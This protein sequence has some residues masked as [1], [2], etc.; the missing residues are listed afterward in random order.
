[1]SSS[2]AL[3][4]QS[5]HVRQQSRK[6]PAEG[7]WSPTPPRSVSFAAER[8][9]SAWST[10]GEPDGPRLR[11]TAYPS[12]LRFER[13]RCAQRRPPRPSP[14]EWYGLVD[15]SRAIRSGRDRCVY[16]GRTH[17]WRQQRGIGQTPTT[18]AHMSRGRY[19]ARYT[20]IR[21]TR[22]N[23]LISDRPL[24]TAGGRPEHPRGRAEAHRRG[25]SQ[26]FED[27]HSP[28][29]SGDRARLS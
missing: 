27:V 22:T 4:L 8:D 21:R 19:C 15:A 29:S 6:P 16:Q 17:R 7:I 25:F 10:K 26:V 18:H 28:R 23:G 5:A 9:Q 20:H 12:R 1:M 13:P 2:A 14:N 24:G 11:M 3:T